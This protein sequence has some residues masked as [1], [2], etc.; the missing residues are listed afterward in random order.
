MFRFG[1]WAYGSANKGQLRHTEMQMKSKLYGKDAPHFDSERDIKA[2]HRWLRDGPARKIIARRFI[3]SYGEHHDKKGMLPQ[4]VDCWIYVDDF[5][6]TLYTCLREYENQGGFVNWTSPTLS[7]LVSDLQKEMY[8]LQQQQ[9]SYDEKKDN[10]PIVQG[11][12]YEKDNAIE[13]NQLSHHSRCS[14]YYDDALADMIR[15]GSEA[16][17]Y[18]MFGYDKCCGSR[19]N[20]RNKIILPPPIILTEQHQPIIMKQ[21]KVKNREIDNEQNSIKKYKYMISF[22]ATIFIIS[23][24]LRWRIKKILKRR[25]VFRK[26]VRKRI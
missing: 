8:L 11:E 5:Q 25:I 14:M 20:P 24:F 17:I 23:V 26:E 9:K 7:K 18:E 15:Y 4:N 12:R 19:Q 6:K 2:F 13:N 3:Q 1:R 22:V 10:S 21:Q 16:F